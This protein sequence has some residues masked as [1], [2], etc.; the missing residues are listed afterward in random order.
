MGV[1]VLFMLRKE[2]RKRAGWREE[3]R[4]EGGDRESRDKGER[5]EKQVKEREM[6]SILANPKSIIIY[7]ISKMQYAHSANNGSPN[8]YTYTHTHTPT[9]THT[10]THTQ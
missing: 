9:L 5:E 7:G 10:Y 6:E 4:E 8:G 1:S 3:E 2:G